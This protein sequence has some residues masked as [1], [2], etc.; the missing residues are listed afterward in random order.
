MSTNSINNISPTHVNFIIGAMKCGT[1][2]L[3]NTLSQHPSICACDIKEPEF[4]SS[5]N[6]LN[7]SIE[8][9]LQLFKGWDPKVHKVALEASTEYTKSL[10]SYHTAKKIYD[11]N[12][13]AKLIYIIRDPFDRIRSQYQ[14]HLVKGWPLIPLSTGVDPYAI[15]ISKYC[16][17]LDSY[18][19]FFSRESILLMSLYEIYNQP[20]KSLEK[21]CLHLEVDHKIYLPLINS[22]KSINFYLL[23][24]FT[25]ALVHDNEIDL[26]ASQTETLTHLKQMDGLKLKALKE[27]V[28]SEFTLTESNILQIRNELMSDMKKLQQ[29]YDVDVS[30][31]GF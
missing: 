22:N 12:P 8:S 20:E 3:F 6:H 4:F 15:N 25:K 26:H 30:M 17:Q 5:Q 9:Y 14:M 28:Y 1:T 7:E 19:E 23:P 11:F 13:K 24:L 31:W 10:D 16:K 2:T 29:D 18:R 27:R 21:V